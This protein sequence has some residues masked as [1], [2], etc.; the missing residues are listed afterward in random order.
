MLTGSVFEISISGGSAT[1]YAYLAEFHTIKMQSKVIMG[2]EFLN[3]HS[4]MTSSDV[5]RRA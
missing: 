5:A 2:G 4:L 3:D 1:I